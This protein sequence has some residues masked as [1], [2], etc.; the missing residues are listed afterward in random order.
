MKKPLVAFLIFYA[1]ALAAEFGGTIFTSMSVTSWYLTLN[2]SALTPPGYMFGVIWTILYLMM[3]LAV[4]RVWQAEDGSWWTQAQRLWLLQLAIGFS[5]NI[6]FF[7]LRQIEFGMVV[8]LLTVLAVLATMLRFFRIDR[9]AG[10]LMVPLLIWVT[11]ASY[12]QL[13]IMINN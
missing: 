4:W 8:I 1:L 3:A 2:R 10:W 7:G 11:C 5:W 9:L 13:Y 12:L 6:V